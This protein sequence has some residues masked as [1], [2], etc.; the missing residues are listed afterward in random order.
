MNSSELV[1]KS[2]QY[3]KESMARMLTKFPGGNITRVDDNGFV[4]KKNFMLALLSKA[5]R[6]IDLL[7]RSEEA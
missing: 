5:L 3:W 2:K 6:A 1:K 4:T 7:A